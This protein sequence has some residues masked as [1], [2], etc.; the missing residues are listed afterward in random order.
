MLYSKGG[1]F[2]V[3]LT[4]WFTLGFV[5][6]TATPTYYY[7]SIA[8]ITTQSHCKIP[9]QCSGAYHFKY[10]AKGGCFGGIYDL[11]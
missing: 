2:G 3:Y 9:L 10:W 6:V 11:I 8:I 7:C 5:L 1:F 4:A